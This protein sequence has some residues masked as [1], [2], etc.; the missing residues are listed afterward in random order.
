VA[1]INYRAMLS[2]S[3]ESLSMLRA[4]G[5]L[6]ELLER[7]YLEIAH[8][9]DIALDIDWE[10]YEKCETAGK[11][12]CFAARIEG[13]LIGYV[14]YLV[15]HNP[16]YKGSLQAVQDVLYMAPERRGLFAGSRLI[17][18]ADR[19]LAAEGVQ[20][21]YHHAKAAYPLDSV[22]RRNGYELVDTLW[23]KRLD[24]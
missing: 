3:R 11:L 14:V 20:A 18:Y 19:C 4:G 24:R 1:D 2:L 8:F 13:D 15:N 5:R 9:K 10:A 22:L 12:R 6:E 23:A 16:H 21:V 17:A 7:H